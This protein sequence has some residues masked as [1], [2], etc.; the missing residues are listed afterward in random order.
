MLIICRT[1]YVRIPPLKFYHLPPKP[2]PPKQALYPL[3]PPLTLTLT[4]TNPL[5][6]TIYIVLP[7][8][9]PGEIS[10]SSA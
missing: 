2:P 9:G 1:K 5:P 6:P 7:S 8:F 10:L 4:Q 3:P